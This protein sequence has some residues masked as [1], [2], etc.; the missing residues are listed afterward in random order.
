[1]K[2]TIKHL[3]LVVTLLVAT[4]PELIGC[5]APGGLAAGSITATSAVLSWS[6]VSGADHY[7][8]A[9]QKVNSGFWNIVSNVKTTSVKIGG[10]PVGL[11]PNTTYHFMVQTVCSSGF[12]TYS[13]AVS[14]KTASK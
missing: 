5:D 9:W 2:K 7:N 8:V 3:L 14:F 1:M 6:A 10:Y 11:S 4:A 12:S 13:A